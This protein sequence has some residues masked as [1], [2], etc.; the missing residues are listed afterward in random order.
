MNCYAIIITSVKGNLANCLQHRGVP[1]GALLR[2][3]GALN[4]DTGCCDTDCDRDAIPLLL[5]LAPFVCC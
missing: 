3:I 1:L 4:F 2:F 5:L